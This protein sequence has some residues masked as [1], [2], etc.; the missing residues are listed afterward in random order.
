[1]MS[2]KNR[3]HRIGGSVQCECG[4]YPSIFKPEALHLVDYLE[5]M[6]EIWDW[7][8]NLTGLHDPTKMDEE[9]EALRKFEKNFSS[10]REYFE[11]LIEMRSRETKEVR[12]RGFFSRLFGG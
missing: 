3:K 9:I 4:R 1:M 2:Q 12:K 5:E 8:Q 10:L 11:R 6:E 7:V